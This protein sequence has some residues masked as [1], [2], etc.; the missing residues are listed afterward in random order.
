M[1]F[2]RIFSDTQGAVQQFIFLFRLWA[3]A[4]T[5]SFPNEITNLQCRRC[6]RKEGPSVNDG[7]SLEKWRTIVGKANVARILFLVSLNEDPLRSSALS[8][9][10]ESVCFPLLSVAESVSPRHFFKQFRSSR[11]RFPVFPKPPS[12]RRPIF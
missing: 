12:L 1:N 7:G 6:Q 5:P 9:G 8:G 2:K 11:Y 4:R 10:P 3:W